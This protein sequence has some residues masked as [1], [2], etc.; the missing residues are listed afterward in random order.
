MLEDEVQILTILLVV[1][2]LM[3]HGAA[4]AQSE[5]VTIIGEVNDTH[6]LVADS[7][8]NEVADNDTGDRL[9]YEYISQKVK[10]IGVLRVEGDMRIITVVSFTTIE[11]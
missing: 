10:V 9:V 2:A 5:Q 8:I 7:G 4:F 11:E 3:F 6:Q 1:S